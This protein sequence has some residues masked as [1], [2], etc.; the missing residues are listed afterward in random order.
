[1]SAP[2]QKCLLTALLGALA[3]SPSSGQAFVYALTTQ[4]RV[5]VNAV[6]IENLPGGKNVTSSAVGVLDGAWTSLAIDG[7]DWWGL[8]DDGQVNKNG[9][10][11]HDL[12]GEAGW[13]DILLMGGELW[14]LR[15]DG[16]VSID[17]MEATNFSDGDFEFNRFISDGT[18]VWTLRTDGRVHPDLD[19]AL[20]RFNG[21]NDDG[22]NT[23]RSWVAMAVSPADGMLYG[24]RRDGHLQVFDPDSVREGGLPDATAVVALPFPDGGDFDFG[25]QYQDLAFLEDG[26]WL[27]LRLNG[28]IYTEG[29]P[30]TELVNLPGNPDDPADDETYVDILTVGM[31]FLTL[32]ED[33]KL[34]TNID[35]TPLF[36]LPKKSY[37]ELTTGDELPDLS[38]V[39]TQKP[40]VMNY[41]VKGVTGEALMLPVIVSDIDTPEEDITVT[42]DLTTVPDGATWD[43]MTRVLSWPAMGPAG[44]Y[45]FK[46]TADDGA[47]KIVNRTYK[48]TVKDPD[49][50]E[51]KNTKPLTP[52]IKKA[53]PLDN[54]LFELPILAYDRDGD[55]LTIS[56]DES[57]Y[58]F[59]AGADFDPMTNVFT[60]TPMIADVGKT[61]VKFTVNDGT[62][63]KTFKVKLNVKASLLTFP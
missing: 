58:P 42:A 22:E 9:V 20:F 16:R 44:K 7:P 29:A 53:E 50:N 31:D 51:T 62:V 4:G 55:E 63:S 34:Y 33:G 56:V 12:G 8:R 30:F 41:S 46:V 2:V 43:A 6:E 54:E 17:G 47:N 40:V 19:E 26:S 32:R 23:R 21:P 45:S 13:R 48:I 49:T 35:T 52:K 1:M 28:Q 37:K 24:L 3:A 10:K 25:D 18:T 38:E 60:W 36:E 5:N 11:V 59:T 27:A 14:A 39:K 61:T 15:D 57:V